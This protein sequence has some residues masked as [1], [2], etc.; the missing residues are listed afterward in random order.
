MD[1][2]GVGEWNFAAVRAVDAVGD[3]RREAKLF[4]FWDVGGDFSGG[5]DLAG[6]FFGGLDFGLVLVSFE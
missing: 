2:M 3:N 1:C 5:G 4:W 6:D